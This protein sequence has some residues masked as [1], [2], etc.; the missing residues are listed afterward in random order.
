MITKVWLLILE[1]KIY[2]KEATANETN[3][4]HMFITFLRKIKEKKQWNF[5]SKKSDRR[6]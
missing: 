6:K 1:L 3:H 2:T 4:L 5:R